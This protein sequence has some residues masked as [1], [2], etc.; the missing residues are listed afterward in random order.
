MAG[1]RLGAKSH[2]PGAE[3]SKRKPVA[4]AVFWPMPGKSL[5]HF[6]RSTVPRG[7]AKSACIDV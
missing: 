1:V 7:A 4:A 2:L 5:L 3:S 6:I